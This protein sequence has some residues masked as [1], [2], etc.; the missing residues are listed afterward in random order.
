M[1]EPLLN[2]LEHFSVNNKHDIAEYIKEPDL[3]EKNALLIAEYKGYVNDLDHKWCDFLKLIREQYIALLPYAIEAAL[4][5]L[6]QR[7]TETKEAAEIM[8]AAP[9]IQEQAKEMQMYIDG[10][11]ELKRKIS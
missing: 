7:L 2:W 8:G 4:A 1:S 5:D 3:C 11:E 9:F 6:H 10:I